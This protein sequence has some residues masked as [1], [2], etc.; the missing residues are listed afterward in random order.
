M[1][2]S[3]SKI[4]AG[5]WV[6]AQIRVCDLNC[7]PIMVRQKGDPDSGAILLKLDRGR[8]GCSVLSQVRDLDGNPGWMY[9][10]GGEIIGESDAESYIKRQ[11]DR[12]PDLWV[13][14]IEDMQGR[15]ELD[16]DIV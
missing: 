3:S 1:P 10:G 15:Y 9:G 5:L 16:G 7:I 12:D 14:E 6:Q 2:W 11:I 4:K 13:I 8:A